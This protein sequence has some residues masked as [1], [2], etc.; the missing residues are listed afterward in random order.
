M[1]TRSAAWNHDST[2]IMRAG[3]GGVTIWDTKTGK[4]WKTLEELRIV[5]TASWNHDGSKIVTAGGKLKVWDGKTAKFLKE[6]TGHS[7]DC[8]TASWN[9]VDGNR[10]VSAADDGTIFLWNVD[11]GEVTH[12]LNGPCQAL[13]CV[14]W[15]RDG[16][17]IVSGTSDGI[18]RVWDG[19]TGVPLSVFGPFSA[20]F[21]S[22]IWSWDGTRIIFAGGDNF[23]RVLSDESYLIAL[24]GGEGDTN[25]QSN[26]NTR[27]VE[28]AGKSWLS[29]F[30]RFYNR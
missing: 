21:T 12:T 18:L 14:A 9:P 2:K 10:V 19:I 25:G 1:L 30:Y 11:A 27:E 16:S 6:L 4:L 26:E 8:W 17:R 20:A 24:E 29:R 3:E 13:N 15:N 5:N 7:A 23:I 22:V 28:T